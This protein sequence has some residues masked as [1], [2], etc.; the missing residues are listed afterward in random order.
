[1][2]IKTF[3]QLKAKFRVYEIGS[4]FYIQKRTI[5]GWSFD[6]KFDDESDIPAGRVILIVFM[7]IFLI[8]TI[9]CGIFLFSTSKAITPFIVFLALFSV[10]SCFSMLLVKFNKNLAISR[11]TLEYCESII[12]KLVNE[13]LDSQKYYLN[14]KTNK[15]IH[16]F[17]TDKQLR[18]KKLK[19]LD[20]KWYENILNR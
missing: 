10:L 1:M 15:K 18:A 20:K 13:Q 5:F 12:N 7:L 16:Y 6:T 19:R 11:G 4:D 8:G 9:I 2:K 17:Y 3:D 14:R